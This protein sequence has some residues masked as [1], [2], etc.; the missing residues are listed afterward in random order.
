M[1]EL[2]LCQRGSHIRVDPIKAI[3]TY[4]T[5]ITTIMQKDTVELKEAVVLMNASSI[6][7]KA[8]FSSP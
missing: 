6:L 1:R 4:W 2:H 8:M 3:A 5:S 7:Y